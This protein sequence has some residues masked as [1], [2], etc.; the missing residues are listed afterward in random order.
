[1]PGIITME[2]GDRREICRCDTAL[3]LVKNS[4]VKS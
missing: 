4:Q 1:M 3:V 2:R